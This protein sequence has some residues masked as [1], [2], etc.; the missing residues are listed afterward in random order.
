MCAK[1][2]FTKYLAMGNWCLGMETTHLQF[3]N[4][5][6]GIAVEKYRNIIQIEIWIV[7]CIQ[8]NFMKIFKTFEEE[9]SNLKLKHENHNLSF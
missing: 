6:K 5:L 8:N 2:I 7:Y 1:N 9:I 4:L 3:F